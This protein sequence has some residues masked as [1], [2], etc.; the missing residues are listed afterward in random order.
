MFTFKYLNRDIVIELEKGLYSL[1]GMAAEGKSYLAFVLKKIS[2]TDN[3]ILSLTYEDIKRFPR[4]CKEVIFNP[5]LR[6]IILDR[7]DLYHDFFYEEDLVSISEYAL[8]LYVCKSSKN[9][10]K[11]SLCCNI[12]MSKDKIEVY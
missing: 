3:S 8:I 1:G 5:E 9:D 4:A 10:L 6:L 12:E 11:K 7:F 2:L